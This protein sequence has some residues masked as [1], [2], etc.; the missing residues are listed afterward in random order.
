[1]LYQCGS[2]NHRL[3]CIY[4]QSPSQCVVWVGLRRMALLQEVCLGCG[5]SEA[6]ILSSELCFMLMVQDVCFQH[7]FLLPC[8]PL[9][10]ITD[11]NSLEL[12]ANRNSFLCKLLCSCLSQQ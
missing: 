11:F 10:R 8:L 5:L 9:A 4:I 3:R 2:L 12:H 7:L 6:H 1:M